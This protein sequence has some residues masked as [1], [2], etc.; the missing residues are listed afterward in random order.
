MDINYFQEVISIREYDV[1][2]IGAGPAGLFTAINCKKDKRIL[3]LEKNKSPGK[4]LLLSGAG[5]CN[6]THDG[7]LEDFINKYGDNGRFLK[8]ALYTF[9]NK[10]TIKFFQ[11]RGLKM[12]TDDNNKIFPETLKADDVLQVLIKEC[13]KNN[14]NIEYQAS[15]EEVSHRDSYF[16]VKTNMDLYK[17]KYL[18]IATG[19]KSYPNTGSTGNGYMFAKG[20]GHKIQKPK[21]SLAPIYVKDYWFE[22]LS[23]IS[24][25]D[26]PITLWRN[27]KKNNS[28]TGD[29]LFTHKGIS[30]PGI[31][32]FSRYLEVGDILKFNFLRVRDEEGFR[33]SFIEELNKQGKK[34]I[35]SVL[36]E[37]PLPKRLTDR[38][39]EI[40]EISEDTLSSQIKREERN[41]LIEYLIAFPMEVEVLG[42]YHIAM[43]TCGGVS[44]K[45][46]QPKTME[47][48][49]LKG[50]YFAGEVLDIDG[51]T[52]GY[53]IQA[54]LSTGFLAAKSINEVME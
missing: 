6:I 4:K 11:D 38:I 1:I 32:N 43:A 49:L 20:L 29:I 30:G 16:L 39:L 35:K 5:Q 51:D 28:Y 22:D 21:P 37:F 41:R 19:G 42:G 26:I 47:S 3:I 52:G 53:N 25:E 15:V 12:I 44:L 23:G 17:S 14:V 13:K 2:I 8:K 31:L 40:L 7:P 10:D 45:E 50:L 34:S 33:R 54:A 46:I 18:V 48:K 24:L 27:N 36:R 9:T